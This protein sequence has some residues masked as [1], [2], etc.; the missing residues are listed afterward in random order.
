MK[1]E[2]KT[3]VEVTPDRLHMTVKLGD[4][5]LGAITIPQGSPSWDVSARENRDALAA[6][7]LSS[8]TEAMRKQN[9][10]DPK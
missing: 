4:D 6:V 7:F 8:I 1:I 3:L 9:A 10:Y 5:T 2:L